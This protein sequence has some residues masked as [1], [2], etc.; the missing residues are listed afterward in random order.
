[1]SKTFAEFA[2]ERR[3]RMTPDEL[4]VSEVFERAYAFAGEL[5]VA[6][7]ARGLTQKQLADLSGINQADISRIERAQLA[8]TTTTLMRLVE[9]L[10]ARVRIELNEDCSPV[11]TAH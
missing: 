3:A 5:A 4:A 2:A 1:M 6:R 11:P 10:G 8:P 7:K 9:S